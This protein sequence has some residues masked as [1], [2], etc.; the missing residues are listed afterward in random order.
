MVILSVNIMKPFIFLL[1][2]HLCNFPANAYFV[3]FQPLTPLIIVVFYRKL[4][5]PTMFIFID[6]VVR[7][8]LQDG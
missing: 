4:R 7:L 3:T 5:L 2:N 8:R 1:W 6:F